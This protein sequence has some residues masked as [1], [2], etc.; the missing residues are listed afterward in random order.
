VK[1]L[2]DTHAFLWFV[3]N[4][5][6]LSLTALSL[7]VDPSHDLLLSAASYWEIAIKISIGKYRI[8]GAFEEWIEE[9][10]QVN[11]LEILPIKVSHAAIVSGL[12]FHHRDPFDRLL[13][14][15]ALAEG[16]P[17]ISGDKILDAYGVD[18]RW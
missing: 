14:A 4:D 5:S 10:I 13:V 1:L 15:Q 7:I 18:R 17:T 16:I 6:Q 11:A 8:P 2:L 9:Q 12:P 3:L